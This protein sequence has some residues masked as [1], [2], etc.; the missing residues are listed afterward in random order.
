[1]TDT[2]AS[3]SR[4]ENVQPQVVQS[5]PVQTTLPVPPI[6]VLVAPR[7]SLSSDKGEVPERWKLFGTMY[8]NYAVLAQLEIS[9]AAKEYRLATFMY[10]IG[11]IGGTIDKLLPV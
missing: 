2:E 4:A 10:T 6:T 3:Q 9:K 5:Q 11:P 7:Q 8:K 1:M